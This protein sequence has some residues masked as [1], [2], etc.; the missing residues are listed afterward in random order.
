MI[1]FAALAAGPRPSGILTGAAVMSVTQGQ[2]VLPS[3]QVLKVPRSCSRVRGGRVQ[4]GDLI[5]NDLTRECSACWEPATGVDIGIAVE[6]LEVSKRYVIR[7]AQN[8]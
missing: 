8:F 5:A 4:V 2:V 1:P 6:Y 7:P 3:G